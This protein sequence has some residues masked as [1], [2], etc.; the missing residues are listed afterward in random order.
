M[1]K[2]RW[3]AGFDRWKSLWLWTPDLHQ[4]EKQVIGG[5]GGAAGVQCI[6]PAA[7]QIAWLACL[8][9]RFLIRGLYSPDLEEISQ[10]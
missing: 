1:H 6:K 7:A 8:L 4:K 5:E 3:S 9:M 10:N 2:C